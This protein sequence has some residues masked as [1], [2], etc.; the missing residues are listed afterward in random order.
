MSALL[1]VLVSGLVRFA[2]AAYLQGKFPGLQSLI[3]DLAAR[4]PF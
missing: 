1:L 3:S 2:T 4:L